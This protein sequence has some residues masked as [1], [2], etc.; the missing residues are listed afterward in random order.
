MAS[1]G[2]MAWY[3]WLA[4]AVV[5]GTLLSIVVALAVSRV[6]AAVAAEGAE[7]LEAPLGGDMTAAEPVSTDSSESEPPR[8]PPIAA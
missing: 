6:L 2:C 5:A 3:L 8:K 4:I 1:I 7:L